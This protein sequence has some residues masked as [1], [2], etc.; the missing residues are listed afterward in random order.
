MTIQRQYSL[1]N[2]TLVLEGLGDLSL[3]TPG[4]ARP[5][6]TVLINAECHLPGQEKPLTGGREFLESLVNAVSG[7]AQEILSGVHHFSQSK[8]SAGLVQLQRIAVNHHR[9]SVLPEGAAPGSGIAAQ[10][11]RHVDLTTVQLFDL[12]EAVDQFFA[13]SQ[14][15]PELT[16]VLKPLPKR[17]VPS[18]E[19]ITKQAAPAALGLSSV[20][21]AA[22]ALFAVPVPK[23]VQP[24]CLRLGEPDCATTSKTDASPTASPSP[25][26]GSSPTPSPNANSSP[27]TSAS[28]NPAQLEAV[29]MSSPEITDPQ[30]VTD[31][32]EKLRRQID[33]AWKTRTS[34]TQDLV[35]R[36]G[37]GKDGAIVGYKPVNSVALEN[38]NKTPLLD[39]LYIP[40]QGGS[41][42]ASEP[43]AQYKVV[44]TSSGVV[45]VAP[46]KEAMA[47]PIT[48]NSGSEITDNARLEGLLEKLQGQIYDHSSGLNPTFD[49]DLIYR[50]RVSED[51]SVIDF[52]PFSQAAYDHVQETPFAKLGKPA[53]EGSDS[54]DIPHAIFKVVIKPNGVPEIN[55]W[56]GW[57]KE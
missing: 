9:L 40:P 33:E 56:R 2:C 22:I 34:I 55:P 46:W 23:V 32:Q 42:P 25:A 50:V 54:L 36:I 15:L 8:Q 51:G 6:M 57:Q 28:P 45:E 3:M 4:E 5:L 29:L 20:A 14:T 49:K 27:T 44:F 7:Y 37:V 52:K 12:V 13:D 41:R 48:K 39:L 24:A 10:L 43:I 35:Y 53:E 1:P 38:A 17:Y 47:L 30:E 16:L 11:T 31:L 21:L 19:S 26:A 18:G